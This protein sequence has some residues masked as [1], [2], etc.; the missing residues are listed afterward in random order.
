V[1]KRNTWFNQYASPV[2]FFIVCLMKVPVMMTLDMN[3][4]LFFQGLMFL[5]LIFGN[6]SWITTLFFLIPSYMILATLMFQGVTT[7]DE[8]LNAYSYTTILMI[9]MVIVC[10]IVDMIKRKEFLHNMMSK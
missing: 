3:M 1:I 10:Y 9:V 8:Q 4:F 2:H 5:L 6:L 7:T